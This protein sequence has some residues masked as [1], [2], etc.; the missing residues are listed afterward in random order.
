MWGTAGSEGFS[1]WSMESDHLGA[2]SMLCSVLGCLP[3]TTAPG[4]CRKQ[5]PHWVL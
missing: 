2:P 3:I 5:H 4:E 1:L